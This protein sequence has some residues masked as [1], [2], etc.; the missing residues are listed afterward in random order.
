MTHKIIKGETM[1]ASDGGLVR[2]R[3]S[4][5]AGSSLVAASLSAFGGAVLTPT[6]AAAQA[7]CVAVPA[8]VD[9]GTDAVTL[10]AGTYNPGITCVY[11]GT[12]ATVSTAGAITVSSTAGG[13]G[14]NLSAA[15]T[16]AVNWNSTAGM[17]T[18]GAQTNGPVIH[19]PAAPG[20]SG[21]INI[22]TAAITG[23]NVT[24]TYG[25]DAESTG[26][27]AITITNTTGAIN[28]NSSAV[29]AQQQSAVRA[30]STGGNGAVSVTTAGGV[31]GRVRGIEARSSGTG[32]LT[33]TSTGA[34]SVNT[35]A[36]VGV[37]AI[38]A[39]T[40]TGLLSININ[41]GF[42]TVNGGSGAAI[43][44]N[45]GGAQVINVVAGRTLTA[46][47][48]S[49]GVL[50]LTAVGATTINNAGSIGSSAPNV[51]ILATGPSLVLE[52]TGTLNGRMNFTGVTGAST[53]NNGGAWN[54]SGVSL[55]GPGAV[56]VNSTGTLTTSTTL[57]S[58]TGLEALNNS[59][60]IR[61][62]GA[63]TAS[64]E[65]LSAPGTIFTASEGS[66]LQMEVTFGAGGQTSCAA[67]VVADCFDLAGGATNGVT[68]I[69]LTTLAEGVT[70]VF[71]A[72]P[73]VLVNVGG[74]ASHAGDFVLDPSSTNYVDDASFGGLIATPGLFAYALRYDAGTEQHLLVSVPR[75]DAFELVPVIHQTLSV[76]HMT[77]D[78]VV[79]RQADLRHEAVDGAWIRAAGENSE[80]DLI[81]TYSAANNTFAFDGGYSLD[82]ASV[83]GGFDLT[84]AEDFVLGVHAGY[85][86][87]KLDFETSSTEDTLKGATVGI[88]GGWRS[89]GLT[90]DAALNANFLTLDRQSTTLED[91]ST[92]VIS[93]GGRAEAGWILP[94]GGVFY[95]QPL[96]TAAFV[97]TDVKDVTPSGYEI[98]FEDV[99]SMRAALGLR[100]GGQSGNLGLWVLGRAW[101]E[102]ADEGS[103]LIHR[104]GAATDSD[105]TFADDLSGQ[106]EEFGVG[107]SLSNDG[108]TLRGYVAAGAKLQDGIDNYNFSLGLR[109]GW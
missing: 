86:A 55:F 67:A 9:N 26:G 41:A 15:G 90:L 17:V 43:L 5:L 23:T 109:L 2:K 97:R 3:I 37:A 53:I 88:Y 54:V 44:T 106:F 105:F 61:F 36:G 107:L 10:P 100:A 82:S 32:A 63:R 99:D 58:F 64:T 68:G 56:T 16:S 27:G 70:D 59:G 108:D 1:P 40:G 78:A 47:G 71:S 39:R 4:L 34:V 45:A 12:A 73:I 66:L 48:V 7:T 24:V 35:T 91:M 29:G 18:G 49:T 14:I 96:A 76:W 51:A 104:T 28:I 42:G 94:L 83:I 20:W 93:M 13:D 11:M 89:G 72:D 81:Q 30:V 77:T 6:T 25:I 22:S 38:D 57:T 69:A 75:S 65:V 33:I 19:V 62:G 79:G 98:A 52:S 103:V 80:R 31:T 85:V 74:G 84:R 60:T 8:P 21:A 95:V 50:N 101:T 92:N 87:S 46:Q 102:F